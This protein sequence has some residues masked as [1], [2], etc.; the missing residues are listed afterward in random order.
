MFNPSRCNR[1]KLNNATIYTR[2][3]DETV[4]QANESFGQNGVD[5]QC[6]PINP[7]IEVD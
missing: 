1:R 2:Q 4:P 7:L 3:T 5:S 6:R